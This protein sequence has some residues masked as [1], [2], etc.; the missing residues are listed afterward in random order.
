MK[1]T[2]LHFYLVR[3]CIMFCHSEVFKVLITAFY[4]YVV[5][6]AVTLLNFLCYPHD[7]C[8]DGM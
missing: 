2:V 8:N 6:S 4:V 5:R 1:T 3:Y 7:G